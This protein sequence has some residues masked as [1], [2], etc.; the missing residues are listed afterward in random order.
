MLENLTFV[1][2]LY[3]YTL[4]FDGDRREIDPKQHFYRG[5]RTCITKSHDSPCSDV[6]KPHTLNSQ[7]PVHLIHNSSCSYVHKPLG[8][9][10]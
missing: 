9:A 6:F 1:L 8:L 4:S 7:L 10:P 5:K 3:S 2:L